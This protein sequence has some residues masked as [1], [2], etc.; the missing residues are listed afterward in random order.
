MQRG[1]GDQDGGGDKH[2]S[3]CVLA[4]KHDGDGDPADERAGDQDGLFL[5]DAK[6]DEDVDRIF[7][8]KSHDHGYHGVTKFVK[9]V[10]PRPRPRQPRRTHAL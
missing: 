7:A 9:I 1:G 10:A 5:A 3:A 4:V 2:V 6:F 8:T